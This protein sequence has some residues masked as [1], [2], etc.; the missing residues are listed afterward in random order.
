MSVVEVTDR[1]GFEREVLAASRER[2]VVVDFWA[3]W[4]QPCR[5]LGPVL[6]RFAA[7][8]AGAWTLVKVD[9]EA[10]PELAQPFGVSGIPAVFAFRDGAVV[11]QFTGAQPPPVVRKWLSGLAPK[12]AEEAVQQGRAALA[13]GD[14]AAA[15]AAFRAAV[16]H[17]AAHV[18]ALLG[19]AALEP[20]E[21]W[22]DRLPAD[23]T[24][25]QATRKQLLQ[26][27]AEAA[28]A[29]VAALEAALAAD[30]GALDAR[31]PLGHA[32]WA[33]GDREGALA[34]M[35]DLLERDRDYRDDAPRRMFLAMLAAVGDDKALTRTWERRLLNVL[36]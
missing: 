29:D 7:E 35:L 9:V 6:E 11:D 16:A 8:D 23:L 24:P 25:E 19:L 14:R 33:A 17:D 27:G 28:G 3:P 36:F 31:G 26:A 30:P 5:V 1:A 21:G 13:A 2:P 12:P 10:H 18:E 22:L 4:C 32:Q 20:G 15:A 34:A